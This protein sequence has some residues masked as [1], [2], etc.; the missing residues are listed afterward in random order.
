[1]D[2][3][4]EMIKSLNFV[5]TFGGEAIKAW[6]PVA[7]SIVIGYV[8]FSKIGGIIFSKKTI[9]NAIQD[10]L[11][12]ANTLMETKAKLIELNYQIAK[13]RESKDAG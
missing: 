13:L 8:L 2:T 3:L 1:M 12:L 10:N 7:L 6:L 4:L 5:A 9:D 11:V